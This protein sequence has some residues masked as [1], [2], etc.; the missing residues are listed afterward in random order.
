MGSSCSRA[1]LP[2]M[3]TLPGR[4][5]PAR[6]LALLAGILGAAALASPTGAAAETVLSS[7][8]S[9][10]VARGRRFSSVSAAWTAPAAT[11]RAGDETH[12]AVWVGLGGYRQN[13]QALEQIGTG[14]DCTAAGRPVYSSWMELLPADAQQLPLAISPGDEIVASV[15]V[16]GR[17]ATLRLSD[18]TTRRHYSRTRRLSHVDVSSADWIVEAPSGCDSTGNCRQLALADFSSVTFADATATS[19]GRTSPVDAWKPVELLLR[20]D[21]L[22]AAGA[23][24]RLSRTVLSAVPGAAAGGAFTVTYRETAD[25]EA[26]EAPRT[27][28]PPTLAEGAAGG[29]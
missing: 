17:D 10:Y 26:P 13:A 1:M 24:A 16:I 14:A 29:P 5:A 28:V 23:S 15:T 19:S 3:R 25:A 4:L 27:G 6:R 11:C 8:W 9:G 12:S 22:A 2:A 18:L 20:Q 21:V 7:N